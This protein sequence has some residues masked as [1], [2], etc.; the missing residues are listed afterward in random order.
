MERERVMVLSSVA[1]Y[2]KK[3]QTIQRNIH[4][5][6]A[7]HTV[8]P[9]CCKMSIKLDRSRGEHSMLHLASIG[10]RFVLWTQFELAIVTLS[11]VLPI[12]K[13]VSY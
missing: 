8:T 12:R 1:R 2:S 7:Y 6:T 3:D 11:A 4:V 9:A 13:I 10:V 5:V